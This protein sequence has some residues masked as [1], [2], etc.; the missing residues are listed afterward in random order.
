MEISQQ[1]WGCQHLF[2]KKKK[3]EGGVFYAL[4]NDIIC[5]GV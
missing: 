2:T 1:L 5:N 4:V 3:K